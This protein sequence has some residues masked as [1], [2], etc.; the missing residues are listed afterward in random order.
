[1]KSV[2]PHHAGNFQAPDG[3]GPNW[4]DV[5]SIRSRVMKV[6]AAVICAVS[7]MCGACVCAEPTAEP[8]EQ[9]PTAVAE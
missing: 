1:M 7:L 4:V 2:A 6:L 9:A 5:Q 3:P 8:T